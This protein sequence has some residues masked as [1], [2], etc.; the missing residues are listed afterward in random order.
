MQLNNAERVPGSKLE[1]EGGGG[2]LTRLALLLQCVFSSNL[3]SSS[4]DEVNGCL[5]SSFPYP[6]FMVVTLVTLFEMEK[7]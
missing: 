1:G 5:A 3:F 4:R 7:A 6:V 2:N